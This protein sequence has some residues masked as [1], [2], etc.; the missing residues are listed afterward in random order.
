MNSRVNSNHCQ[1]HRL[2]ISVVKLTLINPYNGP[3]ISTGFI[4]DGHIVISG[5]R[6]A[7]SASGATMAEVT[8]R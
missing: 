7:G 8:Y 5:V 3:E 2:S 6:S 1:K 4:Y